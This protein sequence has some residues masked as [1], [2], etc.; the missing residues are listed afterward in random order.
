MI[1]KVGHGDCCTVRV[2]K[3]PRQT[4]THTNARNLDATDEIFVRGIDAARMQEI[5]DHA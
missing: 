3:P 5:A 1:R 4:A 2:V